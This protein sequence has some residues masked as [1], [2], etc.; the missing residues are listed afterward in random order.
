MSY[1]PKL[2]PKTDGRSKY[3]FAAKLAVAGVKLPEVVEQEKQDAIE[4]SDRV[5]LEDRESVWE[6]L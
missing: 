4:K 2:I 3:Y 6:Y 1:S 5:K